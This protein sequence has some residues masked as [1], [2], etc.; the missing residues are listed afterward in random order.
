MEEE[1]LYNLNIERAILNSIIFEPSLFEEIS[2]TITPSDFYLPAHSNIIQAM[3]ILFKKNEPIDEEFIKK[4]LIQKKQFDETVLIEIVSANP[5]SNTQAYI[6]EI[7]E[8]AIKRNLLTLTIEIRKVTLEDD[9]SS[10]EVTDLVEKKLY[11]ITQNGIMSDFKDAPLIVESTLAFIQ[12][13]KAKGTSLLVGVDT[14]FSELN[15]MTTG[16]GKGDLVIIAARPAM[17]KTSFVLNIVLNLIKQNKGVAFFSLEMPAE[18][19]MLRLISSETS[20][21]LQS[22]RTGNLEDE[23]WS[24]LS[25]AF[26]EISRKPLYVDDNGS[27][28]INQL[29]SKLRKLK[30]KNPNIE[31]AVVDYIGIMAGASNKDRH[32]EVSEISRGL[33]LLARELEIPI[34]ALSQLNRGVESRADKRPMMSDLRDSGSIEQDADIIM[35]VYRDDVYLFK[36]EKEREKLAKKEGKE[37]KSQYVERA[38]EKAEIIIGKQRNGPTGHV[39][40]VFQKRFTRFVDDKPAEIEVMHE[41]VEATMNIPMNDQV[42]MPVL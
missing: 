5:I 23:E 12:E 22:L 21:P 38:E 13:M 42:N 14:G 26:D 34:L 1:K 15:R 9:L 4:I 19:L 36:E 6:N 24:Q 29:R 3:E 33:K 28:N 30:L 17:G 39:N 18:Q 40:L 35:F 7:R 8:K 31:M 16:F 41:V 11:E 10:S 2:S 25:K 37:Y 20:I 32:I 27:L